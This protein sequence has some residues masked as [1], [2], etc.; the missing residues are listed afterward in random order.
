MNVKSCPLSWHDHI[1]MILEKRSFWAQIALT[2][3]M[4]SVSWRFSVNK[5]MK[6]YCGIKYEYVPRVL[7]NR[8]LIVVTWPVI[9]YQL[10]E[11]WHQP[12]HGKLVNYLCI[13]IILKSCSIATPILMIS[14]RMMMMRIIFKIYSWWFIF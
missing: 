10:I 8:L 1:C 6:N 7:F 5:H 11:G 13:F 4:K 9:W 14:A 3:S 2:Q 12:G